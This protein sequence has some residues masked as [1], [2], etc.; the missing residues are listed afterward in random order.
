MATNT[1]H[2]DFVDGVA[3]LPE[4]QECHVMAGDFDYLLKVRCR[5]GEHLEEL[6]RSGIRVAHHNLRTKQYAAG[7]RH[8]MMDSAR[9]QAI[10]ASV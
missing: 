4:I 10:L 7:I 8:R 2:Q 3:R 1:N 6:L 5:D 9:R